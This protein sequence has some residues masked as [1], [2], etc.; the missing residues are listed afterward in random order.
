MSLD[1]REIEGASRVMSRGECPKCH[2][3]KT[4]V[5]YEDTHSHCFGAGC[6]YHTGPTDG[7]GTGPRGGDAD[8]RQKTSFG[9]ADAGP[10]AAELIDP[11]SHPQAWA[12]LRKRGITTDTL[13]RYGYFTGR[14]RGGL[15]GVAPYYSQDGELACQKLR[16]EGKEFPVLRVPDQPSLGRCKL[17][18]Q[19]YYGDR[20]DRRVVVTE[21]ELDAMSVAQAVD[22]KFACVSIP[23]GVQGAVAALKANYLWL[24]RFDEIVLWF[25]DDDSGRA[26]MEECAKLFK[27]GKVKLAKAGNGHKDASDLLQAS[28]PGDI[29]TAVFA[30]VAWRPRG[31]VNAKTNSEDVTAPK[32]DAV[33]GWSFEWPWKE[34]N[35][36]LGPI[37]AGQVCYHVA[38]TGVGKTTA[39]SEIEY[40]LLK[41]NARIF[42]MGFE[43]TR[44]DVKLRLLS[45]HVSDRLDIK[46]RPD[47][48]MVALHDDLFGAGQVEMFDPETAEW[49]VD[50]IL[51]YVR[52]CAKALDCQ[53]GFIDPLTFI[54]AGLA[55]GDDER[56]AL[57]KVSRDLAAMSKE[58]GVHLQV[59]HHLTRPEGAG[60]EEGAQTSLNQV[61]GSGGIANFA[62]FVIGHERNGQ[63]EGELWTVTQYR[64]LKNRPRSRTGVL[65]ALAFSETK[66][67]LLPTSLAFPGPQRKG[68]RGGGTHPST[69]F[70][71]SDY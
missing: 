47:A 10:P 16:L 21:G 41:Q 61:R 66:G 40:H 69:S 67:R 26:A 55:V 34:W 51:G 14:F 25:D 29:Q 22:F 31:I 60:H 58:L 2:R 18:G 15:V 39:I 28:L 65:N 1:D 32:E 46:P 4:L 3:E 45:V 30:A 56:R 70:G 63:A 33:A 48:E 59:A 52:Y 20:Y 43:D 71:D 49:T 68:G 64:A 9:V 35:D 6:D 38:G 19:T 11:A 53:V 24:D 36:K 54:A 57:D 23:T 27:V 44:R 50:A 12:P 37:R 8:P 42:H 7:S 17:F 5:T 62:S 13:R